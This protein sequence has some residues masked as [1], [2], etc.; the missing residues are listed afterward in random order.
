MN[1]VS[2]VHSGAVS[3]ETLTGDLLGCKPFFM[4]CPSLENNSLNIEARV[5]V[6]YLIC[7]DGAFRALLLSQVVG[8][9]WGDGVIYSGDNEITAL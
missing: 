8:N 5:K 3:A 9:L 4:R 6:K 1:N 7:I 2:T